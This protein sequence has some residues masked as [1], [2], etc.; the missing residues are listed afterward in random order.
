VDGIVESFWPAVDTRTCAI[1]FVP[2]ADPWYVSACTIC[3]LFTAASDAGVSDHSC[4][5]LCVV[6][7]VANSP[8]DTFVMEL[9]VS[10]GTAPVY[11]MSKNKPTAYMR[12]S[13]SIYQMSMEMILQRMNFT[14]G[15]SGS[16]FQPLQ[17]MCSIKPP[18]RC[19]SSLTDPRRWL[20]SG[21]RRYVDV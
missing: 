7:Y 17:S 4:S 8:K 10:K 2:V 21:A 14:M 11:L 20:G 1:V 16:V 15:S 5:R 12:R 6:V 3:F 18:T 9:H 13:G 19:C